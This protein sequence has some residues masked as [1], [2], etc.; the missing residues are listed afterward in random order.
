MDIKSFFVRYLLFPLVFLIATAIMTIVNKKNKLLSNKRLIIILLITAVSLGIPGLL[1][2]LGLYFMPWGY[3][4]CQLIY[5]I[6]GIMYVWL[7]GKYQENE[8][9][10][11]KL[12]FFFCT[13]V[14]ALLG[15]FLFKLGFNWLNEMDYGIV[16]A[17]SIFIFFVPII[18]WWTY[19]A[20]LS[21]PLEIYKIWEYPLI[22]D[23]IS[24]EH[25]DF[26]RLLV[27]EL[28]LYK[29]TNDMEPLKV[30]AKAPRNMNFGLWFQKFIDDYNL[31]FP[32]APVHFKSATGENYKWIFYIKPSF[33]K[34]RS[35]IDPELDIEQNNVTENFTIYA[36]RVSEIISERTR[37]ADEA[38]FL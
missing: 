17:S 38:V 36:K 32:D 29:N 26:N 27:L 18:F 19:I 8:L 10:N 15:F 25:L 12:F 6:L 9:L 5:L 35:F 22:A 3:I 1:G 14:S 37:S 20:Y 11:K 24:M 13:L 28:D 16:A 4:L 33:F 34:Q 2:F 31:K 30:K 7:A 23:D 21:I